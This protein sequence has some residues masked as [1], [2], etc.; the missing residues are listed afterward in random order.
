M[1]NSDA[2]VP[3]FFELVRSAPYLKGVADYH[4]GMWTEY[5]SPWEA[6]VYESGRLV[7]AATGKTHPTIVDYFNCVEFGVFPPSLGG[8]APA[9]S[10]RLATAKRP[11]R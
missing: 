4:R 11:P 1:A 6:S 9:I 7:A 3:D 10:V 5:L 2:T 8:V